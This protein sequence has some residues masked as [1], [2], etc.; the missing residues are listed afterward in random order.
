M[1]NLQGRNSSVADTRLA[2]ARTGVHVG[3]GYDGRSRR[4]FSGEQGAL[5]AVPQWEFC[6]Y[7]DWSAEWFD[8]QRFAEMEF[9]GNNLVNFSR[10]R[11]ACDTAVDTYIRWFCW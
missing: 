2:I 4:V 5:A 6:E 9:D 8:H 1:N 3:R 7:A 10:N 11:R